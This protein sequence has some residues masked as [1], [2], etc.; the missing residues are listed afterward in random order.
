MVQLRRHLETFEEL[1][2][3]IIAVSFTGGHL[4]DVWVQQ[5]SV[6][7]TLV[8]DEERKLYKT[9]GLEE[10]FWGSFG[11]KS[12]WYYIKHIKIPRIWGNPVQL[13]GDFLLDENGVLRWS[14]RSKDNTDR[15]NV[16]QIIDKVR[17]LNTTQ[18]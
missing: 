5:T 9:F 4:A 10:S 13:G 18:S 15:P 14:Y 12:T 7:F 17:S 2:T 16:E 3:E 6:P 8:I 11:F 1:N